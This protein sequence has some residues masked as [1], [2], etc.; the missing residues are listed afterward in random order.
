MT[1]DP[2]EPAVIDPLQRFSSRGWERVFRIGFPFYVLL[3]L[4]FAFSPYWES[5][6]FNPFLF[7]GEDSRLETCQAI[8]FALGTILIGSATILA[9]R[10]RAGAFPFLLCLLSA[11]LWGTNRELD[12]V[13][14]SRNLD[15]LYDALKLITILPG[16]GA[17]LA[18]PREC[19]AHGRSRDFRKPLVFF[20]IG[21]GFYLCGQL[22]GVVPRVLGLELMRPYKR[23]AEEI[24]ELLGGMPL[25]W[26]AFQVLLVQFHFQKRFQESNEE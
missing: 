10:A 1:H 9:W 15:T 3:L 17:L 13:W 12:Q 21:A 18:R 22:V 16:I 23:M 4:V 14:E 8:N 5:P 7:F 26:G 19:L 2:A 20:G 11:F 6:Y 24:L 25:V